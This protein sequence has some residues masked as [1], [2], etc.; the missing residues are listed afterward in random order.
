[1][2]T[3][4]TRFIRLL[5]VV[6]A[7]LYPQIGLAFTTKSP[8]V[9]ALSNLAFSMSYYKA[10]HDGKIP[11]S[12]QSLIS[13][14][15]LTGETLASARRFCDF[16]RRYTLVGES[17]RFRFGGAQELLVAIANQPGYEGDTLGADGTTIVPGRYLMVVASSGEIETRRYPEEALKSQFAEVGKSLGDYTED[18]PPA[19]NWKP[20]TRTEGTNS[21]DPSRFG[22]FPENRDPGPPNPKKGRPPTSP[23]TEAGNHML[24]WIIGGVSLLLVMGL[25][26]LA[27]TKSR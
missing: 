3:R 26:I 20:P 1:M 4:I 5:A 14:G 6:A 21:D 8:A 12:W 15:F 23:S 17:E 2:R 24:P 18:A 9:A 11:E 25:L 13:E 16:E 22:P 27:K 19:P 10:K 7:A